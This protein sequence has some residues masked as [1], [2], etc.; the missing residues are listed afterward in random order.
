VLT[1]SGPETRRQRADRLAPFAVPAV[2]IVLLAV[3]LTVDFPRA[4]IAFKGDEATY[5]MLGH[6]L[7]R[8]RDFTY[9]KR[10]LVRVWEEYHAPEGVFLKKGKTVRLQWGD[11]FPWVRWVKA[12][13]PD[14]T[15]LYYSK[16][17]IYPLVAAPL[18]WAFGTNGFLVLHALLLTLTLW[19][20]HRWLVARGS[21]PA[22]AA[23]FSVIFLIGSVVPVYFVSLAPEIFNYALVFAALFLWSYKDVA[24][25]PGRFLGSRRSDYAAAAL[26]GV[27]TFSKPTHAPLIVPLV[28]WAAWRRQWVHAIVCGIVF[29]AMTAG[30]FG[31]NAAITGEFNYQGGYRKT[32]YSSIG[33]PFANE[34]ETFESIGNVHGRS[35]VMVDTLAHTDTLTVLRHN[36]WYFLVGR[37][38]GLV[39]YFFPAVL[40]LGLFL[41][42]RAQRR[43]WQWLLVG[44]LVVEMLVL[45]LVTPYTWAGGGGAIGNRY[46]LSFYPAFLFLMPAIG[47]LA[48]AAAALLIGALFTAKMVFNPFWSG[49]HPGEHAKR[50]PLRLLPIELTM[51]NDLP[52]IAHP[53]RARIRMRDDMLV[54]FPDDNAYTPEG[55]TFWLR[56]GR[57]ADVIVRAPL[58]A[59][60][61]GRWLGRRLARLHVEVV[62]G[63]RSNR[64]TLESRR[65]KEVLALG[66]HEARTV[67]LEMPAGVPYKPYDTPTSYVY[68]VSLTTTRGFVPFLET[69]D[70]SDARFLGARVT[71]VP[72]FE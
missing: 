44:A 5:Y 65:T 15:R 42:R 1:A 71:L 31:L 9:E 48:P 14:P 53:D 2:A 61:E 54:Y 37:Y 63:L 32:F 40:A 38:S 16:A 25:A 59:L 6:S 51:L 41:A 12:D 64:V 39:P 30:L 27:L 26:I 8:D 45:L 36:V 33:F 56:G 49:F 24:A 17:Y 46:F 22:A 70:S 7:A 50:G 4:G 29:V 62:N 72:E 34:R 58:Q 68:V 20:G 19:L 67:T 57:R 10:D 43:G 55:D 47:T 21:P 13:D 60:G 35:E 52:M 3:A 18:V 11:G 23:A 69:P 66:P 28:L